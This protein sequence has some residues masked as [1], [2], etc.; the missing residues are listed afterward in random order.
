M[1]LK[2]FRHFEDGVRGGYRRSIGGEIRRQNLA[3]LLE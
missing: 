1:V 2:K 3:R